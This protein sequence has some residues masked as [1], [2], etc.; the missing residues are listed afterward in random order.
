MNINKALIKMITIFIS[1]GSLT[2]VGIATNTNFKAEEFLVD[3]ISFDENVN[4]ITDTEK[5]SEILDKIDSLS[6]N[7]TKD[8]VDDIEA[9]IN[10]LSD[11]DTKNSLKQ[12]LKTT[13]SNITL[14]DMSASIDVYIQSENILT[15]SLDT[16]H[17][18]FDNF[19]GV[20]DMEKLRAIN[21]TVNSTLPY[22]LNASLMTEIQNADGTKIMNKEILN[23]KEEG[24]TDYKAFASVGQ[25]IALSD[26]NPP[27]TNVTHYID[28]KLNGKIP[29][30][31]DVYKTVVQFEI[32]QK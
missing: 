18:L 13:I 5:E 24:A 27:A 14:S 12:I 11:E 17:I 21:I 2:T 15:M 8:N 1:L 28:L 10:S 4:I 23:I 6:E 20:N 22:E 26:N 9:L 7:Y 16:N 31:I 29:Y 19:D 25:K 32:Q 30:E 3:S